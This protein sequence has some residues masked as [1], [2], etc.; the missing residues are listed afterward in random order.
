M[1]QIIEDAAG[2]KIPLVGPVPKLSATPAQITAT[3]PMLGEHTDQV[4]QGL[5]GYSDE[6]IA[7]LRA[8][9]AI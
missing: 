4:L 2:R 5:L 3:P 1:V 8:A 9:R 7:A 6:R